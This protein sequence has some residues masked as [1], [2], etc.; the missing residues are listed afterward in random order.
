MISP[1][2]GRKD[3]YLRG[4]ALPLTILVLVSATG[5]EQ[6]LEQQPL[7]RRLRRDTS[8]RPIRIFKTLYKI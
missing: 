4:L 5:A 7:H 1:F 3:L 2:Q 8:D 6:L